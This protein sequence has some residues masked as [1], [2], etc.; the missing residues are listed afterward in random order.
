MDILPMGLPTLLKA[1][2]VKL[3]GVDHLAGVVRVLS[4]QVFRDEIFFMYYLPN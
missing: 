3:P 4:F 2:M 1:L